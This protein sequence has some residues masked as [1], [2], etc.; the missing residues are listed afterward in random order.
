MT[1]TEHATSNARILVL[2]IE[3]S[4]TL[5]YTFGMKPHW[6]SPEKIVEPSRMLCWG[7][8]WVG[9]PAI[10]FKSEHH[11][12]RGAMIS[13]LWDALNKADILVTFN[14]I[15]FDIPHIEREFFD[16]GLTPPS[17]WRNVDLYRTG[18]RFARE[19]GSLNHLAKT[20]D[21]GEKVHHEGFGLWRA[22][23]AGDRQAWGRMKAYQIGDITLTE[24]V[25]ERMRSRGWIQNHPHLGLYDDD[26]RSC[27]QCGSSNLVADGT[28]KTALTAYT[29]YRCSDCGAWSRANIKRSVVTMR[30]VAR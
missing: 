8:K 5:T 18:K 2:D 24:A 22:C 12:G 25:Y 4:P 3:T 6:I 27:Y 7:A 23:L 15:R 16:A 10:M 20:L 14:G 26:E 9:K 29:R 19:S 13:T 30:P 17:P 28:A 21:L 11:H 1:L